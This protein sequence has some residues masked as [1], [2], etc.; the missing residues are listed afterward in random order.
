VNHLDQRKSPSA[1]LVSKEIETDFFRRRFFQRSRKFP[2]R[3]RT[4]LKVAEVGE[5]SNY[6]TPQKGSFSSWNLG[7]GFTGTFGS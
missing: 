7:F 1:L 3:S 4:F 5:D 2:E 6:Q